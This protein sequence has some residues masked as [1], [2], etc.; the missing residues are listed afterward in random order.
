MGKNELARDSESCKNPGASDVCSSLAH[1]RRMTSLRSW[2]VANNGLVTFELLPWAVGLD[3]E[4]CAN[5][6]VRLSSERG[7]APHVLINCR[8]GDTPP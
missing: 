7:G 8:N 5:G 1:R 4:K 6:A 3:G 2:L